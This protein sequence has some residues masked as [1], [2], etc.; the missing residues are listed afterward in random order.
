MRAMKLE[1]IKAEF[2]NLDTHVGEFSD[3][4]FKMKCDVS[5]DEL[6][7]V[8]D[9]GKRVA[10]M[11]ARNINNVHLE[12]KAIRIQAINFEVKEGEE[13]SVL[14][15]SIR[16]ELGDDAETWYQELWG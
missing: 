2:S 12:K 3:G 4:K 14:S 1:N 10:R 15:G 9:G 5:Y 8:M 16:L 7:L 6:M 11:H 13:V